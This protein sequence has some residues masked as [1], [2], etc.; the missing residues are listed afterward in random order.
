MVGTDKLRLGR[1]NATATKHSPL[2][3]VQ[4]IGTGLL[5]VALGISV[6]AHLGFFVGGIAGVSLLIRYATGWNFGVVYFLCNLPF[7]G[8]A[9]LR[10]G[11]AFTIKTIFVVAALSVVTAWLPQ[12]LAFERL[13]PLFGVTL[14]GILIGYGMLAVFRHGASVGGISILAFYLQDRFGWRAGLV[15]LAG[16]VL[17]FAASFAFLTPMAIAYSALGALVLNLFVAINHRRDRYVA[18]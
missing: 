13:D 3:D 17:I 5:L 18:L 10:M 15:L 11:R 7:F 14:A 2:E 1:W 6:L 4:G 8:L 9:I 12:M 16:D